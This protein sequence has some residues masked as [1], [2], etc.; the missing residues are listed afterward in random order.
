MS[1]LIE[2]GFR[3]AKN[4]ISGCASNGNHARV[5]TT[6]DRREEATRAVATRRSHANRS[7][8]PAEIFWLTET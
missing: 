8:E 2:D 3:L 4:L 6:R 1:A 5:T 7:L